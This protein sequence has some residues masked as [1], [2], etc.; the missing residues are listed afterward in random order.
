MRNGIDI[1]VGEVWTS[2]NNELGVGRAIIVK[3]RLIIEN[4]KRD[5]KERITEKTK[6]IGREDI[7]NKH[8][9]SVDR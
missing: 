7:I 2:N 6:I 3:T 8:G 4:Y 5:V 9:N 1:N